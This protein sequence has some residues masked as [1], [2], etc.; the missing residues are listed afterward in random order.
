MQKAASSEVSE[1]PDWQACA[2]RARQTNHPVWMEKNGIQF[3]RL[4]LSLGNR[5][6]LLPQ[7]EHREKSV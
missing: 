2:K 4:G 7:H 6:S 1:L 5:I 3:Y